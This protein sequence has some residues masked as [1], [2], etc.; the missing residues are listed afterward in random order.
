MEQ[1]RFIKNISGTVCVIGLAL[2][3]MNTN[4]TMVVNM[5][6][7]IP[8]AHYRDYDE[9][10]SNLYNTAVVRNSNIYYKQK[11]KTRLENEAIELFGTMRDATSEERESVNKYIRNISKDTG[12]NFFDLC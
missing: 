2:S 11:A 5:N 7:Q 9:N 8:S 1:N 3:T 12:V 4:S 10:S 6:Y